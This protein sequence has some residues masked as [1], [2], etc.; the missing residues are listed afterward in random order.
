V[1]VILTIGPGDDPEWPE[2]FRNQALS[3]TAC[4]HSH[5]E[6]HAFQVRHAD[7]S[8]C[9]STLDSTAFANV[10]GLVLLGGGDVDPTA[11]GLSADQPNLY[12]VN[13]EVDE[14]SFAAVTTARSLHLPVLGICRG[15][16]V[17]NVVQG[18]TLVPDIVAWEP[19]RGPTIENLF[20]SETV[21]LKHDSR[22]SKIYGT[23]EIVV[24][25]AH[26][27]AI[28]RVGIGLVAT[29][30]A[31]DGIVEAIELND[32]SADWLIGIQ[33][34]PEHASA[35]TA[36]CSALF[37]GFADAVERRLSNHFS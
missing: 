24:P 31:V 15:A 34:H 27:Q 28:D 30:W 32:G 12:G 18:G 8:V 23:C 35:D 16:Q 1:P 37:D 7:T 14:F 13:R 21:V 26:H 17:I 5:L 19:H 10:A 4:V 2:F 22:L 33:W 36:A 11:Y 20:V 9:P 3:S 25:N 29:G 6:R